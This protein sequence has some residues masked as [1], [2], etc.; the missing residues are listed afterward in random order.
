MKRRRILLCDDEA[1]ARQMYPAAIEQRWKELFSEDIVIVPFED[2]ITDDT[3]R[4]QCSISEVGGFSAVLLDVVWKADGVETSHGVDIAKRIRRL[5]PEMPL[6]VFSENVT[7][8][9]FQSLVPLR[10]AAYLTKADADAS[11]WCAAIKEA[12]DRAHETRAG[13]PLYQQL[14]KLLAA[15][16]APWRANEVGKAASEVWEHDNTYAKWD[17]FWKAW[18]PVLGGVRL[19]APFDGMRTFFSGKELLTLSVLPSMRGHLDHVVYV[20]F[21]GYIMSHALPT[22]RRHVGSAVHNLLGSEFREADSDLHWE[23]FQFA[24]LAA[25]TLHDIAYPLE[26][27]PDVSRVATEI[28]EMFEFATVPG[29]LPQLQAGVY[30]PDCAGGKVAEDAFTQIIQG[31]YRSRSNDIH[32]F[33]KAHQAFSDKDGVRRF[34]HGIAS[35][36][37]FIA[38]ARE[39]TRLPDVPRHF[40]LFMNWAATAMALHA[41][42]N[43]QARNG[44]CIEESRD[45]LAFLLALCDELQVW[46]RDRPDDTEKNNP[47]RRV[48][49]VGIDVGAAGVEAVVEY[50]MFS[51]R[52]SDEALRE[53]TQRLNKDQKTLHG[54][55]K[56]GTATITIRSRIRGMDQELPCITLVADSEGA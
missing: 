14:R 7:L 55:L 23:L 32:E 2:I 41:L 1:D 26:V 18:D 42:K 38:E 20:Y 51:G 10:I 4:L 29:R 28:M 52:D 27:L 40:E 25:A 11:G 37:K 24:W 22:F 56:P 21:T 15:R 34:N 48:D 13:H 3:T 17:A 43:V 9:D 31:L 33:V 5:Y 6:I 45:P 39:W 50:T 47:F 12:L 8:T 16:P 46:N 30:N 36:T 35:G 53:L 19:S 49:L 44:F 54:Y